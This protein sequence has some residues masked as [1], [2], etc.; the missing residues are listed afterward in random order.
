M[1]FALALIEKLAG[2]EAREAVEK[3]L[4]RPSA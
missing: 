4:M 2:R 1:D 3:P